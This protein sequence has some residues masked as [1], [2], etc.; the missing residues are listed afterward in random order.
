MTKATSV[1]GCGVHY[2]GKMH[3]MQHVKQLAVLRLVMNEKEKTAAAAAKKEKLLLM[4]VPA[5]PLYL[6]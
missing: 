3:N 1:E 6:L 5:H 4:L 2:Y